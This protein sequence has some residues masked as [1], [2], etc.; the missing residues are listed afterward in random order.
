MARKGI[1][2]PKNVVNTVNSAKNSELIRETTSWKVLAVLKT[3][4]DADST[5]FKRYCEENKITREDWNEINYKRWLDPN[6]RYI[7]EDWSVFKLIPNH[8]ADDLD[9]KD[10]YPVA[11]FKLVKI[12]DWKKYEY[13]EKNGKILETFC[14]ANWSEFYH[15]CKNNWIKREDWKDIHINYWID[16]NVTYRTKRWKKLKL[17]PHVWANIS[18]ERWD[19]DD[20]SG[21]TWYDLVEVKKTRVK[22]QPEPQPE[23]QPGPNPKPDEHVVFEEN[24]VLSDV[25]ESYEDM[26]SRMVENEINEEWHN[27]S[28]F[29]VFKRGKL[30]LMR[31]RIRKNKIAEMKKN[32]QNTPFTN[33]WLIN[34]EMSTQAARHDLEETLW[35]KWVNRNAFWEIK[36]ED[37]ISEAEIKAEGR[38]WKPFKEMCQEYVAWSIT[39]IEFQNRFNQLVKTL[40]SKVPQG[41]IS[42]NIL[43]KLD[44]I[45]N[46][47]KLLEDIIKE[48]KDYLKPD[49]HDKTSHFG[50]IRKRIDDDFKRYRKDPRFRDELLKILWNTEWL[51]EEALDKKIEKFIRHEQAL[52]N[53]SMTNLQI[54]LDLLTGGKWAYQT[55]NKDR[56][57][58]L[59]R[60]GNKL[61]K[62]PR[63]WQ[64]ATIAW[65]CVSGTAVAAGTAALFPAFTVLWL[66]WAAFAGTA[67]MSSLV[68]AKNFI[69]KWTHHTKEQNTYEK[70]LTRNYEEEIAKMKEWERIRDEKDDEGK[71]T[72]NW[73][74]RYRAKRQLELY[75]KTTQEHL[76][77]ENEGNT[78]EISSVIYGL[79]DRYDT[80]SDE[81]RNALHCTLLDA[82]ARLEVYWDKWHNFL[83]SKDTNQIERDFYELENALNL[84]AGRVLNNPKATLKDIS[85]IM[86]YDEDKKTVNYNDLLNL[87]KKDYNSAS[88]KFRWERAWLAAKRWLTTAGITFGTAYLTQAITWT[89]MHA[90]DAVAWTPPTPDST[91]TTNTWT[92][93]DNYWIWKYE[94]SGGNKIFQAAQD[95]ISGLKATDSV[96]LHLWSWTDWTAVR[97]GSSLLDHNT[98]LDKLDQVK[99]VIAHSSLSNK[100]DLIN[101]INNWFSTSGFTNTD[102]HWM[103]CLEAIEE[104][105]KG[106]WNFTGNLNISYDTALNIDSAVAH[107]AASRMS[108]A[109]LEISTVVPG[110]P[111]REAVKGG[112]KWLVFGLP[113][114]SNTFKRNN[115]GKPKDKWPNDRWWG[116]TPPHPSN[117]GKWG[118]K[119]S[120]KWWDDTPPPPSNWGKWWNKWGNKWWDD[121][122]PPPSSWGKSVKW[123]DTT[124]SLVVE[125]TW[126]DKWKDTPPS[127]WGKW[128]KSA[129]KSVIVIPAGG[130]DERDET[131]KNTSKKEE[132]VTDELKKDVRSA[133]YSSEY[134]PLLN[135]DRWRTRFKNSRYLAKIESAKDSW[136]KRFNNSPWALARLEEVNDFRKRFPK[137]NFYDK[138]VIDSLKE[139]F[140][141]N[142][143]VLEKIEK[144]IN[145][146]NESWLN[147]EFKL[148][149]EKPEIDKY[150]G[151]A[152]SLVDSAI[153]EGS[154]GDI[155]HKVII[156]KASDDLTIPFYV[157]EW[158]GDKLW[159]PVDRFYPFFWIWPGG[160]LNKWKESE[161]NNYYGSPLLAAIAKELNKRYDDK[162][163]NPRN[164]KENFS[165]EFKDKANLWKNPVDNGTW[166]AYDNIN[167][168]L[169]EISQIKDSE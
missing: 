73:F 47:N 32:Y 95:N 31:G 76:Q 140:K 92:V 68:W 91:S 55:N 61:D 50:A 37:L 104:T 132:V 103:R 115:D 120:D 146:L 71:Y 156:I 130:S 20:Y 85:L 11:S 56:E 63:Y 134:E 106:A 110:E 57:N 114:F 147:P 70:N 65:I 72:H 26:I 16:P 109:F 99:D 86:A 137:T 161:I 5:E 133:L 165:Q 40:W 111:W 128:G 94:L 74:T 116:N 108:Q 59:F 81:E 4:Y 39:Q 118:D 113:W 84:A 36:R 53:A 136:N 169:K 42:T 102:L 67:T 162:D 89:W 21:A 129:W 44:A 24:V 17:V 80:L 163:I 157:S 143:Y 54:K 121:T 135:E 64:L 159:V 38:W 51:D 52:T 168:V 151:K 79:L 100:T 148:Y 78:K 18:D 152:K 66:N 14:D 83:K 29:N 167:E 101:Q 158:S 127:G 19:Y 145:G 119:W 1:N 27:T 22:P 25:S 10:D 12:E 124:P 90:K 43:E 8:W 34:A 15:Y 77:N 107:D 87:Y 93:M 35:K 13:I 160:R 154:Y 58:W 166:W 164:R 30:F 125:D 153:S 97:A 142:S 138:G 46:D 98:Y 122:P 112:A 49:D 139:E 3:F 88:K 82:K 69:K 60:F 123:S 155:D 7:S 62:M 117:W 2:N 96:T 105:V 144:E 75:G 6:V 131:N 23:P 126:K 45:K 150:R 41:F 28:K 149:L 9:A 141:E 48:L 33:N